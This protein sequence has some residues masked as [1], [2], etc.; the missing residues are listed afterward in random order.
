MKEK[1]DTWIKGVSAADAK[2]FYLTI[3]ERE[4]EE[5]HEVLLQPL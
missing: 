2:E 5:S 3:F 4:I 1:M